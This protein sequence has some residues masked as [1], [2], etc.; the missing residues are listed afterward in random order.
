LS[1]INRLREAG[2]DI[3]AAVASK[4]DEPDWARICMDHLVVGM[5]EENT[6]VASAN[7]AT[8]ASATLS[9]CFGALVEIH[10]DNKRH[11]LRRLH[12]STN[13]PYDEMVFFDNEYGNIRSVSSLGVTCI[14][15]PD[16]MERQH[17][18]DAKA[19]FGLFV[20]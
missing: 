12:Q 3:R 13:I 17:W 20:E 8:S 9:E 19:K 18:D 2:H 7:T 10:Y 14:Y 16:G 1:E 5:E 15:T 11:H 6:D 4:T